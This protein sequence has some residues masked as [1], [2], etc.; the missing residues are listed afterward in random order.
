MPFFA[1][2]LDASKSVTYV[3]ADGLIAPEVP[4]SQTS[5]PPGM[6]KSK[7][8]ANRR[9][10][11]RYRCAPATIGKVLSAN[12]EL[13]IAC[14]VDLSVTGIGMQV[15]QPIAA[16]GLVMISIKS[17]DGKKTFDLSASVVHCSSVPH[18]EWYL[19]CRLNATLS[20]ED[21]DSLL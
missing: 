19:G 9:V 3:C 21:L 6:V 20:L 4:V 13:Q 18:N 14:I 11:V 8:L 17:T 5:V 7:S 16:G 1:R 2:Q 10:A 12:Q 15:P